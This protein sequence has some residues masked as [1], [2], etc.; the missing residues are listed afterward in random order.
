[1]ICFGREVKGKEEGMLY[2]AKI[3]LDS[4][5]HPGWK[6]EP[7]FVIRGVE[8]VHIRYSEAG[9]ETDYE[10]GAEEHGADDT[11]AQWKT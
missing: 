11:L 9:C 4:P 3:E 5:A 1:M 2:N 7:G 8:I 10:A 6:C